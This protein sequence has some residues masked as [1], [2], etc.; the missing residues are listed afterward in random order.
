MILSKKIIRRRVKICTTFR[1]RP[2]ADALSLA[3]QN[4][5]IDLAY[6]FSRKIM[7]TMEFIRQNMLK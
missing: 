7:V 6:A 3:G 1:G 4:T 5:R 2:Y